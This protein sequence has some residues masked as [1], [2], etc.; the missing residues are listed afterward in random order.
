[1]LDQI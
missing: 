1:V